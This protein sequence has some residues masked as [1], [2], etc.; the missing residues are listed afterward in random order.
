[1]ANPKVTPFPAPAPA[2]GEARIHVRDL[3][4]KARIGVHQHERVAHQRIRL[5]LELTVDYAKA[6]DDDLDNVLCYARL[7]T[8]IR[9]VIGARHVNLIET[10][11]DDI[12]RMCLEDPRVRAARVRIDKL[13]VFPEAESI[14]IEV[15]RR[16]PA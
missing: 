8:G 3:V 10:L 14:G 9:G 12:A 4:L 13:D 16:R 7:V 15:E 6:I 2:Y 5:N 1:M 11:A